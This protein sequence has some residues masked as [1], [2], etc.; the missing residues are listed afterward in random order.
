MKGVFAVAIGLFLIG[1]EPAQDPE[2]VA[3]AQAEAERL[4]AQARATPA[5]T[6]K[7]GDWMWEKYN[8]P[9]DSHKKQKR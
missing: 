3:E 6:P 9:L 4:A 1:C 7:P 8:N 2:A 5:A